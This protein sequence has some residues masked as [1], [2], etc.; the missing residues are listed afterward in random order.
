MTW[1]WFEGV[2]QSWSAHK[3]RGAHLR[4][5]GF[6][7]PIR[8]VPDHIGRSPGD[9]WSTVLTVQDCGWGHQ[10]LPNVFEAAIFRI[11]H[12]LDFPSH[13]KVSNRDG[14]SIRYPVQHD[15]ELVRL[16]GGGWPGLINR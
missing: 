3:R 7:S 14:V 2:S 12:N 4:P 1:T 10:T 13:R 8:Q 11:V 5:I 6:G 16:R 15:T 9:A